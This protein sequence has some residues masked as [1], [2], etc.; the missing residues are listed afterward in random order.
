MVV[1]QTRG[2]SK[3]TPKERKE[4][5]VDLC[6]ALSVLRSP[7]EVADALIDLLTPKEVETISKRLKIA[8]YLVS[9]KEYE[10]IRGALKVGY[11]T[12]ARVNTWLNISGAGFK[13]IFSR[14]KKEKPQTTDEEKYD[15]FSWHNFKRRYSTHFWPQL[16]IEEI[17]KTSDDR[18]KEKI[19]SA[20]EKLQLK[21][22][23]FTSEE[24][25]NLYQQF[26]SKIKRIP[27]SKTKD[28]IL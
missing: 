21:G 25:K 20:F 5:M 16:L 27:S 1:M 23:H 19:I 3:L 8:E 22:R 4:L 28:K 2:S 6:Q 26:S 11:S 13:V 15:P 14:K 10:F 18:Q 17:I 24:N 7:D 12:I 9:G